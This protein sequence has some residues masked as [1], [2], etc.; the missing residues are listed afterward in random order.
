MISMKY[1]QTASS[2]QFEMIN[3][4]NSHDP[5][6]YLGFIRQL[7]M[8]FNRGEIQVGFKEKVNTSDTVQRGDSVITLYSCYYQCYSYPPGV[9]SQIQ[10]P[11]EMRRGYKL[12]IFFMYHR[13]LLQL[14]L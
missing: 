4:A 13:Q 8:C 1:G 3:T 14:L 10:H 12:N 5:H 6:K 11:R 9:S 2:S 7:N